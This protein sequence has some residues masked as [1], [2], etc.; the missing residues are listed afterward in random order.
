MRG[1]LL[2]RGWWLRGRLLSWWLLC[3]RRLRIGLPRINEAAR[4]HAE[5]SDQR[6]SDEELIPIH[7]SSLKQCAV[8]LRA[9]A[10]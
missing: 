1:R 6:Q 2:L 5:P 3:G 10:G 4:D 8:N 9:A 7:L